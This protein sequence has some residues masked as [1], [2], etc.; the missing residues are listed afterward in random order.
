MEV[1][2]S[3]P[4]APPMTIEEAAQEIG[5]PVRPIGSAPEGNAAALVVCAGCGHRRHLGCLPVA[6]QS[7]GAQ[8]AW[9]HG[10][11]CSAV[12]AELA[13]LA[14]A[15]LMPIQAQP[16][17]APGMAPAW[18]IIR[19]TAV[20]A[21]QDCRGIAPR[22]D[23][24]ATA[25]L[26]EVLYAARH[27]LTEATGGLPD[28]RTGQDLLPM[29]LQGK[30]AHLC[31]VDFSR[32][33]TAALWLGP[34]LAAVGL[35]RAHGAEVAEVPILAVRPELQGNGLGR[36]LLA[37]L[38]SALLAAGVKLLVLP[39]VPHAHAHQCWPSKAGYAPASARQRAHLS[40]LPLLHF[41]TAPYLAKELSADTLLQVIV[42]E[43]LKVRD[44][45]DVGPFVKAKLL[46]T[47]P[48]TFYDTSAAEAQ[49][50]D[51]EVKTEAPNGCVDLFKTGE[52]Q[53]VSESNLGC[54]EVK[55]NLPLAWYV[56][57]ERSGQFLRSM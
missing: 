27:V 20:S 46:R 10:E 41:P 34:T 53:S 33:H 12:D 44:D 13:R 57:M 28:S 56:G 18:Q 16:D 2:V 11:A 3:P 9:Y 38:E 43:E 50:N 26:R 1:D 45:V 40:A 5:R 49:P 39:A 8:G 6:D 24:A 51:R 15:G 22:Y 17:A 25:Q 52:H 31:I 7:L 36:A 19:G 14:A 30:A 37:Q 35:V 42:P 54:S 23:A 55:G 4:A 32:F 47:V 29:L 48:L 21:P